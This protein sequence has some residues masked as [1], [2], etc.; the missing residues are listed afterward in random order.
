MSFHVFSHCLT[1]CFSS[2]ASGHDLSTGGA[3]DVN[4][5]WIDDY[6]GGIADLYGGGLGFGQHHAQH[7]LAGL[8]R[9][10]L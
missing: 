8:Q 2:L 6:G 7:F 9:K 5:V 1:V 10:R 3:E 4:I